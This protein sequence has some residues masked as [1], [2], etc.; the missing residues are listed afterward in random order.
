MLGYFGQLPSRSAR[1]K[2]AKR[3]WL[4]GQVKAESKKVL[5]I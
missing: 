5:G 1:R 2:K 4:R 3:Q